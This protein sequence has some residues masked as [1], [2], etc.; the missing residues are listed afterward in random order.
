MLRLV[1]QKSSSGQDISLWPRKP[2]FDSQFLHNNTTIET[3]I[4]F[5]Q[6]FDSSGIRT[7]LSKPHI[8]DIR[9]VS[10][11]RSMP[12]WPIPTKLF[13]ILL[14]LDYFWQICRLE[15]SLI[16]M[17]INPDNS[18]RPQNLLFLH[19]KDSGRCCCVVM[20]KLG[21]EPRFSRPQRDVLTT[22]RF[23]PD[24]PKHRADFDVGLQKNNQ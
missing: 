1:W 24:E 5:V 16:V 19:K 10:S 13:R 3:T 11:P 22:G 17:R 20:Q 6:S 7:N 9:E 2:G 14:N 23:L 8:T 18:S 21:I 12:M 15:F 4:F